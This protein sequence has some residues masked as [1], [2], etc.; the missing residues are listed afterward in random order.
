MGEFGG[1]LGLFLG[2]SLIMVMDLA[3]QR[4][5]LIFSWG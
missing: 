5:W 4:R 3:L 2:F 1:T